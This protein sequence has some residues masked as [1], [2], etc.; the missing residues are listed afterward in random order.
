MSIL[1][2]SSMHR[3]IY[4]RLILEF[5][6]AFL[7]NKRRISCVC[8]A[9]RPTFRPPLESY[10]GPLLKVSL[11]VFLLSITSPLVSFPKCRL[12][13]IGLRRVSE[14]KEERVPRLWRLF[15]ILVCRNSQVFPLWAALNGSVRLPEFPLCSPHCT[16]LRSSKRGPFFCSF[17][18]DCVLIIYRKV[19]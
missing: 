6:S 2:S 11:R 18:Q 19:H 10:I 13:R 12:W 1:N 8:Q 5:N 9:E 4:G 7:W 15:K 17:Y 3:W 14:Q 16:S